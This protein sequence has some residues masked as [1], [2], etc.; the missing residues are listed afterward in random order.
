MMFLGYICDLNDPN[1]INLETIHAYPQSFC[2]KYCIAD[3]L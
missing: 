3:K 1:L 2:K